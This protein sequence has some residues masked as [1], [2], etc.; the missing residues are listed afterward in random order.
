MF[1]S[2]KNYARRRL[3]GL[4]GGIE[5][6]TSGHPLELVFK[7]LRT[8]SPKPCI[9]QIGAS[10]GSLHDPLAD[11]LV[12]S[13]C[14]ALLVEPLPGPFQRLAARHSSRPNISC[15]QVAIDESVGKRS[16][17]TLSEECPYAGEQLSSFSREHLLRNG[18]KERHIRSIEVP[19]MPLPQLL[20]EENILAIDLLQVDTEGFD[21][22]IVAMALGVEQKPRFINFEHLHF[23]KDVRSR[24]HEELR[25]AG[26]SWVLAGWD[27]L[28][29]L[30][31]GSVPEGTG[32]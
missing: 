9:V 29:W 6:E 27:T 20:E 30:S 1:H 17:F 21:H 25:R 12:S 31:D 23:G 5:S 10:D 28:A 26:Y 3:L 16:I 19:T 18:V 7:I 4:L 13:D 15:R 24:L 8:D 11:F 22:V 14:R 2:I 32:G